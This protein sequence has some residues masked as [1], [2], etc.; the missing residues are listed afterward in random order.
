V[1]VQYVEGQVA[2]GEY[3]VAPPRVAGAVGRKRAESAGDEV[4]SVAGV[5]DRRSLALRTVAMPR[6]AVSPFSMGAASSWSLGRRKVFTVVAVG[7]RRVLNQGQA[8][9]ACSTRPG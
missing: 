6:I 5:R 9:A 7:E 3:V 1:V 4:V 8:G 2:A